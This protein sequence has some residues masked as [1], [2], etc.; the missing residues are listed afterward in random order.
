M[1]LRDYFLLG[2]SKGL[3]LKLSW[4]NKLFYETVDGPL[5]GYELEPYFEDDKM[6]FKMDGEIIQLS[7]YKPNRSPLHFR[8]PFELNKGDILNYNESE[9][10]V[11]TYGNIYCNH[12]CLV[13]PFGDLFKFTPGVFDPTTIEKAA[14]GI[15]LDDPEDLDP[16]NPVMADKPNI[17]I[18]QYLMFCDH[19]LFLCGFSDGYVTTTTAKSIL[20]SPKRNQIRDKWLKDNADRL[21]SPEAVAELSKILKD[22]DDEYLGDDESKGYYKTS[23]KAARARRK[24]HYFF[25]GESPFGDG[26]EVDLIPKSL[27][28]GLDVEKLP[29]MNSAAR[30]GAYN[31]GAETALGGVA[32][33]VMYRMAG[34][35]RIAEDDCKS[36]V[37]IPV[38]VEDSNYRDLIGNYQVVNTELININEANVKDLIG[39]TIYLRSPITCK[40]EGKNICKICA[41]DKLAINPAGIPAAVASMGGVLM[42]IFMKAMHTNE[43]ET[44]KWDFNKYLN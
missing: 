34:T 27:E 14:L 33:K 2:L 10:I 35:I 6:F 39:K 4:V 18:W 8:E 29:T 22:L 12:L 17:Y 38:R 15:A 1:K 31:R 26:S 21:N 7:D 16:E 32:T 44:R 24:M 20:G 9:T 19:A 5:E 28:E 43:I 25:G 11:T 41:G 40:T 13:L 3:G 30:A 36:L 37:G 42:L 23:G